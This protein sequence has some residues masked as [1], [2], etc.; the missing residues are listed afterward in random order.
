MIFAHWRARRANRILI[1]QIHGKIVAAARRPAL[2]ADLGVADTFDGR[3][4]MVDV[5]RRPRHAPSDALGRKRD[6]HWRMSLPTAC[7][8]ISR[9]RCARWASATSRVAGASSG[10]RKRLLWPQQGLWR[11]ARRRRR[12]SARRGAGAQRLRRGGRRARAEA[13]R[14]ARFVRAAAGA[15][16][17][18]PLE[19]FAAGDASD[20]PAAEGEA[21][22]STRTP[23]SRRVRVDAIPG[24]GLVQTIEASPDERAALATLD[25]LPAIAASPRPSACGAADA[26]ACA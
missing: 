21:R 3:F 11:G 15:L 6:G 23:F 25:G 22:W 19:I 24:E 18:T 13:P 7:F 1:D 16:D 4:E 20:F 10:W 2:Y 9:S 5:A 12:R 17:Q 8:A 14:L 26:A